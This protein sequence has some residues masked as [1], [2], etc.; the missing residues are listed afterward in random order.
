MGI[1]EQFNSV[2]QN[3]DKQR[4]QLIP[5]FD[6]YYNLPLTVMDYKG[7][8]PNVLDL[9]CGTGLFTSIVMQKYP[10]AKYTLIDISDKML[11]Q[12]KIRFK[13]NN[14]VEFIIYDYIN[15]EF[16]NKFD[17]II[18]ALSIHHLSATEKEQLYKKCYR[19]LNA[20]GIFVNTDQVL[21]PHPEIEDMFSGLWRESII[22]SGIS[23]EE[24]QKAYARVSYDNPSTLADQL[25]WLLDAGFKYADCIY[26]YYHFCVMYAK[27]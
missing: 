9:G 6:D 26:K 16:T 23:E 25:K 12:A 7:E 21:S 11:E 13:G 3:Y 19:L 10:N 14:K 24:L 17:I 5:C 15:Y 2:S 8:S 27:K 18:S 4:R 1:K 22:R 20:D